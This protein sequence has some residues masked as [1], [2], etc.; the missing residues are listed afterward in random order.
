MI[1]TIDDPTGALATEDPS[2]YGVDRSGHDPEEQ[3]EL[4]AAD[5]WLDELREVF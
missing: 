1:W 4:D 2:C 5:A 3:R